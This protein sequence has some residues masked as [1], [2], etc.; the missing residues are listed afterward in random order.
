MRRTTSLPGTRSDC[1]A[2]EHAVNAI[3]VTSAWDNHRPVGS[4]KIASVYS[5]G[6]HAWSGISPIAALTLKS[7]RAM[8]DTSAPARS[9]VP[10]EERPKNAES[11]RTRAFPAP[12]P[13]RSVATVP[14]ASVTQTLGPAR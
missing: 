3:L 14:T 8:T 1:L 9:A 12:A 4:S 6:V 5:I 2:K 11:T 13:V 10:T 7:R